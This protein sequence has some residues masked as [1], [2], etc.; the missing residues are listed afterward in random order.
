MNIYEITNPRIYATRTRVRCTPE[1]NE[2]VRC[3]WTRTFMYKF[4]DMLRE[5]VVNVE[6][7]IMIDSILD[8]LQLEKEYMQL[9][10]Y[11]IPID[12]KWKETQC[13]KLRDARREL[14]SELRFRRA[15]LKQMGSEMITLGR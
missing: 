8:K 5:H 9:L 14:L 4:D 3:N 15:Q 6:N 13:T 11:F 7:S 10:Q 1:L 12:R 2:F